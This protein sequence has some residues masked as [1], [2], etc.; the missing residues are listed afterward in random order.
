MEEWWEMKL[1]SDFEATQSFNKDLGI[2]SVP[3][4]PCW[5]LG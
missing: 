5:V 3:R 2:Y 1:E 4:I